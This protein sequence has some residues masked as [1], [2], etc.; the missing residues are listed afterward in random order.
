M[1]KPTQVINV[2]LT[3]AKVE[4]LDKMAALDDRSRSSYV[5]RLILSALDELQ[6]NDLSHH[7]A[8][9]E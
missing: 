5:R 1:N 2:R 8:G 4:R 6:D 3:I 7:E 9:A